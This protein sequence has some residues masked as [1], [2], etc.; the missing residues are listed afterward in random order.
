MGDTSSKVFENA[1]AALAACP[2][3][4]IRATSP[5]EDHGKWNLTPEQVQISKAFAI[6][7]KVNGLSLPFPRRLVGN[8]ENE[9]NE[10]L[11]G[12]ERSNDGTRSGS[13][14]WML[15]HHSEKTFGAIP[16]LVKGRHRGMPVSVMVDVPKFSKSSIRAVEGLL[17]PGHEDRID[18]NDH[19]LTNT[20]S[21]CSPDFMFLT[22]VDDTA[23]HN[24]WKE[25]FRDM[26][27]I[28]HEGDLGR[29]NW[30]GDESL[31]DVEV[32]LEHRSNVMD[33]KLTAMSLDGL[34]VKEIDCQLRVDEDVNVAIAGTAKQIHAL[35]QEW[36]SDFIIFHTPGHSN[37]SIALLH[38]SNDG[39]SHGTLFTGD[40]YAFTTRD[41]GHMTGFPR[42]GNDLSIQSRT[43]QCIK[44]LSP[45]Y[46]RIACG[47]GHIRDYTR[48]HS[49][50]DDDNSMARKLS[51]IED[52]MKE[53]QAYET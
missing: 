39:A 24:Q 50:R 21:P 4:A 32:L 12:E 49:R 34:D 17:A 7:T 36:E 31:N 27:R 42:Y 18:N 16:Y 11:M 20:C 29:H 35:F 1:R 48:A 52:A 33:E 23:Q 15:G 3:A 37:G 6:N 10:G 44:A 9:K 46:D 45:H 19:P 47:H 14:V 28:F 30:I 38:K 25:H 2:V 13:G 40:T 43:L 41:G 8:D 51:D 22:H 26:K 5:G 53:L